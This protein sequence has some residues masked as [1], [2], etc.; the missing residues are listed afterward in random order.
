MVQCF[1]FYK[2]ILMDLYKSFSASRQLPVSH[3]LLYSHTHTYIYADS[4]RHFLFWRGKAL[5]GIVS[6][7]VFETEPRPRGKR[8]SLGPVSGWGRAARPAS[9][10]T[11][12]TSIRTWN[13]GKVSTPYF[14]DLLKA[15]FEKKKRPALE[16]SSRTVA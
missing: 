16:N 15:A 7:A 2:C 10:A 8:G 11:E 14:C 9:G 13:F 1:L 12:T 6:R 3:L 5:F 4:L